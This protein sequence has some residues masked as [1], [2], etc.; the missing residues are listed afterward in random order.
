MPTAK[1][2]NSRR[3]SYKPH[4]SL[5]VRFWAKVVKAE[6]G[7]WLWTG[8]TKG[9]YGVVTFGRRKRIPAHRVSWELTRGPIPDGLCVLHNC[10]GGDN[11]RCVNP[12]HLFVG[13]RGDNNADREAKGRG[14]V[15]LIDNR[16]E[17]NGQ[18]VL[19]PAVVKMIR[20]DAAQGVSPARLAGECGAAVGTVRNVIARRTWRHV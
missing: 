5:P 9:G 13:T 6:G 3:S 15:R 12:D 11:P 18:A 20:S 17:R 10:P 16:G 8:S 2:I 14:K 1:S 7:C 4:G 19:T